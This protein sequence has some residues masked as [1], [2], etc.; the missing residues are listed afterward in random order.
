[1]IDHAAKESLGNDLWMIRSPEIFEEKIEESRDTVADHALQYFALTEKIY[2]QL[3]E[4]KQLLKRLK[5]SSVAKMDA[6]QE[7]DLYFRPGFLKTPILLKRTE[8][9]LKA[10]NIRLRRAF[11]APE[12]DR[13]KGEMLESYIRKYRIAE[14]AVG[15]VEKSAGL[16]DFLLL[17]EEARISIYAPEIR[18]LMKC[19]ENIL[20]K[21][22][23]DL[24]LR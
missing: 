7:L 5:D 2:S 23:Q 20:A 17:L 19:S 22:W 10:L 15:G 13:M 11:D 14:E 3:T 8:R 4:T 16:L 9:Y 6:E 24:R 12:K 21:A 1:M 18:P